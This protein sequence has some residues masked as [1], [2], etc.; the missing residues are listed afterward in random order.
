VRFLI[1]ECLSPHLC[2]VAHAAGHEAHH[3]AHRGWA[4]LKDWQLLPKI[5]DESLIM[6]TNNRDD[7][8]TLVGNAELHPGLVVII[9][10]ARRDRQTAH[11]AAVL[12]AI[13]NLSDLINTLVEVDE[14]SNV[15]FYEM[16]RL[17]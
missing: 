14:K 13:K 17:E 10:N 7:F 3:V 2:S 12:Q 4:S 16:P 1:D 11:F 6:V 9:E 8:V 15:V 5:L